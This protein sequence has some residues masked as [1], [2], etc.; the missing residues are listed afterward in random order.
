MSVRV[1]TTRGLWTKR[2]AMDV[3]NEGKEERAKFN[4]WSTVCYN[5]TLETT[6][7]TKQVIKVT[8][9]SL[10]C[11]ILL[12]RGDFGAAVQCSRKLHARFLKIV[13][14]RKNSSDKVNRQSVSFF[15]PLSIDQGK[16]SFN[17]HIV[18][19]NEKE[20]TRRF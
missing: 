11:I 17:V 15:R 2:R 10:C 16:F 12:R 3:E 8:I 14:C 20:K 13:V 5:N 6:N 7:L 18:P 4:P 1:R 19:R 9:K